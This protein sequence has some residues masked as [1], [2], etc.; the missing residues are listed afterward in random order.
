KGDPA[1]LPKGD[2]ADVTRARLSRCGASPL[3]SHRWTGFGID[4][5]LRSTSIGGPAKV[6]NPA[7]HLCSRLPT[8]LIRPA[9]LRLSE[10]NPRQR[11]VR[12]FR[13]LA[14]VNVPRSV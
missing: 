12:R 9:D 1:A 6:S 5:A 7:G 4:R 13:A 10:A 11:D 2:P 8:G 14:L 3:L